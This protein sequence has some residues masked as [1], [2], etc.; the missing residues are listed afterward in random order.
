[1]MNQE[2]CPQPAPDQPP[3]KGHIEYIE[4]EGFRSLAQRQ[5]IELPALTLLV[6]ANGAGKSNFLRFFEMLSWMLKTQKLQEFVLHQG[7]GTDLFFAGGT[8]PQ[9][10]RA[11]LGVRSATGRHAYL[12][13]LAPVLAD[14]SVSLQ[15]EA[16]CCN[17][18]ADTPLWHA[19]RGNG[20][21]ADLVMA[22]REGENRTCIRSLLQGLRESRLY[23]FHDTSPTA[24]LRRGWDET[25]NARLRSDGAN[26]APLLW[27]LLNNDFPCYKE[28]VERIRRV[29]PVFDDFVLEPQFGKLSLRWKSRFSDKTFVPHL[30]SDGSLR[31]F[32]LVSLLSLP[33]ELLPELLLLDEPELGLHPYAIELVGA[34]MTMASNHTQIIAA[35]QSS[36]LANQVSWENLVMVDQSEGASQ[37]R[38]L[39][40]QEV[41]RW[42]EN[43]RLGELWEMN[44]LGGNP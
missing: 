19:L 27:N 22:N 8:T 30:T 12:F 17:L 9:Q 42:L 6:G 33:P 2:T 21:E 32:C 24:A 10:I 41:A 23:Q 15:E 36:T 14:N 5:C 34:L 40:E 3:L 11:E 18:D 28:I 7:G 4:I 29:L 16:Y 35:T 26:L 31:L 38:H 44:L 1:M 25:D 39:Q 43:F 37:L 20:R 13:A